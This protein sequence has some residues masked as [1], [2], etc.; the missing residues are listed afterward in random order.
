[1]QERI[2]VRERIRHIH[3]GPIPIVIPLK[4][5]L[6]GT[7][8]SADISLRV[9]WK[10]SWRSESAKHVGSAGVAINAKQERI[11]RVY[12]PLKMRIVFENFLSIYLNMYQSA[13]V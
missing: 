11:K 2:K 3:V 4:L 6:E 12:L 5:L 7:G 9:A 10:V 1:M 8:F 13:F